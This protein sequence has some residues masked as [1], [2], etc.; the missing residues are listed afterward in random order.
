MASIHSSTDGSS[1]RPVTE[2]PT[3]ELIAEFFGEARTLIR[4]ELTLAKAELKLEAQRASKAAAMAG[5]A[6]GLAAI[7]ALALSA[8]LVLVLATFMPAWAA[9]L[10]V[11]LA[12]AAGAFA[13]L[14]SA[15]Q[16]FA[17]VHGPTH[18]LTA[19]KE[20]KE[21]ASQTFRAAKSK[22]HADA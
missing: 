10:L 2:A 6:A 15:K 9:A 22:L 11:G 12:M 3:K 14:K 16:K 19:L 21:W 17:V 7:A 1:A 8:F 4:G 20:D 13:F 5:A 18:T